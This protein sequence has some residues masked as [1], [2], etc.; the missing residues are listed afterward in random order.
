MKIRMAMTMEM[1]TR[2]RNDGVETVLRKTRYRVI[3]TSLVQISSRVP[4]I[5][6]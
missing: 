5:R 1:I 4:A 6:P 2:T 3:L